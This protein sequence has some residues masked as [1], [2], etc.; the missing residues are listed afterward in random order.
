V[1]HKLGTAAPLG[2]AGPAGMADLAGAAG[3]ARCGRT[4][5][6]PRLWSKSSPS[7]RAQLGCTRLIK[8]M[9]V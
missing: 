5:P 3:Q 8:E 6:V 9:S 2:S 1:P 4:C 7:P